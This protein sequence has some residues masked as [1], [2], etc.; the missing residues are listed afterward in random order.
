MEGFPVAPTPPPTLLGSPTSSDVKQISYIPPAT[1]SAGATPA[2]SLGPPVA[3]VSP[4]TP[5]ATTTANATGTRASATPTSYTPKDKDA[6]MREFLLKDKPRVKVVA[7]VGKGNIVT[8]EEV[9]QAIRQREDHHTALASANR[10]E[11]EAEM[12]R[13]E[14]KRII[15]RELLLDDVFGKMKKNKP[16][17]IDE[18]KDFASKT[19]DKHIRDT[20]RRFNF[21]TD[22]ELQEKALTPQGLTLPMFRRRIER[23]TM[24]GEYVRNIVREKAKGIGLGDIHEFYAKNQDKFKTPDRVKWQDIFIA[25]AKFST[26]Q[27]AYQHAE[28]ARRQIASG[29]D[30]VATVKQYDHAD[31]TPQNVMGIGEERGK[32]APPELE[33]ALFQLQAGQVSGL[34]QTATGYH[35]VKALERENAG[36]RPFDEKSQTA[37]RNMLIDQMQQTEYRRLVDDLWRN[38]AVFFDVPEW[39]VSKEQ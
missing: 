24:C 18:I 1:P 3:L 34:I 12:Y 14:L 29:A 17:A 26:P 39:A 22:Q 5:T 33:P 9:W 10:E 15:E 21:A 32:I 28:A 11:R 37:I 4:Q 16:G 20:R 23:E 13:F 2:A 38:G 7:I 8:D 30:F 6:P 25:F 27:E 31:A 19:A 35:I 36:I